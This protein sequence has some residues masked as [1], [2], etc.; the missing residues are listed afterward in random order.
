MGTSIAGVDLGTGVVKYAIP[1]GQGH[2]I[3]LDNPWGEPT[4]LSCLYLDEAGPIVGAAAVNAGFMDPQKFIKDWKRHMG[5]EKV[6]ATGPD[7]KAWCAVDC[8]ECHFHA[9]KTAFEKKMGHPLQAVAVCVPADYNDAQKQD[10]RAAVERAGL[11]L[12]KLEHEPTAAAVGNEVH[13]RGDGVYLVPDLGCGTFDVSIVIV[14]GNSVEILATKGVAKLGGTDFNQRL[15]E[16]ILDCFEQEH[17]IRPGPESHPHVF[18]DL[19][20]RIE[21][22]KLALSRRDKTTVM[23]SADGK[24]HSVEITRKKF[25]SLTSDLMGLMGDCVVDALKEAGIEASNLKAV[26]ANGGGSQMPMFAET[27]EACIGRKPVPHADPKFAAAFGCVM[28]ARLELA[29]QGRESTGPNGTLPPPNVHMRD[30]TSHDIGVAVITKDGKQMINCLMLSKGQPIPSDHTQAFHL[31]QDG[32]TEA[33]IEVLQGPDGA[34]KEECLQIGSCEITGMKA[35]HDQPHAIEIR[36]RIDTH[37]ILTASAL[38]PLSGATADLE[39]NYQT[40]KDD[41]NAA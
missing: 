19:F 5:T 23:I 8:A 21:Q 4:T 24:F 33:L 12:V 22:A 7:G 14:S 9:L 32:Q 20:D 30:I 41:R 29:R 17:G 28:S 15:T 36:L 11:T 38:D 26:I 6:L 34:R 39:I 16:Y 31:S 13:K 3:P 10:T 27:L 25:E 1:D 37:G 2:P 40:P 18:Q 35:V